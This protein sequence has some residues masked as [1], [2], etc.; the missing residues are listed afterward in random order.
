MA[1][2]MMKPAAR[3]PSEPRSAG[4]NTVAPAVRSATDGGRESDDRRVI[5][6]RDL[7]FSAVIGNGQGAEGPLRTISFIWVGPSLSVAKKLR[8]TLHAAHRRR[9]SG[10]RPSEAMNMPK[11]IVGLD[12][13]SDVSEVRAETESTGARAVGP[14][15]DERHFKVL[16]GGR[17]RSAHRRRQ[18]LRPCAEG[19]GAQGGEPHDRADS[20]SNSPEALA[21]D[22]NLSARITTLDESNRRPPAPYRP[23]RVLRLKLSMATASSSTT[24]RAV[25][26]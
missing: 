15:L 8:R 26:W 7:C 22:P 9:L 1:P 3:A 24:P 16:L 20:D 5:G 14:K 23:A 12:C 21:V 10:A 2:T 13:A 11:H 25:S 18:R 4:T 6:D 19:R 17:L